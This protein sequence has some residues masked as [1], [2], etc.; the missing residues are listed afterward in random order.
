MSELKPEIVK[1][2][3]VTKSN[4]TGSFIGASNCLG[5]YRCELLKES[6]KNN[7]NILDK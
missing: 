2:E 3:I 5:Q 1:P 6:L 7:Q 4:C